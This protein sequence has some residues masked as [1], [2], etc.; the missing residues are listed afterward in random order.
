VQHQHLPGVCVSSSSSSSSSDEDCAESES[1]HTRHRHS[2]VLSGG[3]R[4]GVKTDRLRHA[5]VRVSGA[6]FGGGNQ[7]SRDSKNNK[8]NNNNSEQTATKAGFSGASA[9]ASVD[10]TPSGD[11]HGQAS[12]DSKSDAATSRNIQVFD[13]RDTATRISHLHPPLQKPKRVPPDMLVI[14]E[15]TDISAIS[16]PG[17]SLSRYECVC[18]CVCVCV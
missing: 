7:Q 14:E 2:H 18:M 10:R 17:S 5:Q 15:S 3:V 16:R 13:G 6:K 12:A 8:N 9:R 1:K 4:G 11:G